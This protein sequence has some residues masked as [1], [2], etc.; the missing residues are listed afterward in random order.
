MLFDL[1]KLLSEPEGYVCVWRDGELYIQPAAISSET[2]AGG[3]QD[4]LIAA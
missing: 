4:D 3:A 1:I 2:K